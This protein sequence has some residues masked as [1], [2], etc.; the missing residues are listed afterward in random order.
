MNTVYTDFRLPKS[1]QLQIRGVFAM[2]DWH[3]PASRK[4]RVIRKWINKYGKG[5]FSGMFNW[6]E[7][8]PDSQLVK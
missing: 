1:I 4:R 7:E 8:T 2:I 5:E 3:R 6:E